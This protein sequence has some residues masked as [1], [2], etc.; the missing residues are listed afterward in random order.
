MRRTTTACALPLLAGLVTGCAEPTADDSA[1]AAA[2]EL[3]REV[4]RMIERDLALRDIA[5]ERVLA[6]MAAVPRERF[7][8]PELRGR[9]YDDGPLPIGHGQ[10][11]SQPYVVAFMTQAL[12]LDGSERVLE[13]GTGSGYQAAVLGECAAE[14][15]TIEIVEPLAD[16][17]R[18]LLAELGYDNVHVRTGDGYRGWPE[19]APFDAI[20]VTAAPDHV[21]EPLV[22]QLAEGGRMI[23]PVGDYE[24]DL[25]L[26]VKQDGQLS[27]RSVLPVRFVPMTGEARDR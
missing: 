5:D 18:A 9:A 19:E 12:E 25:V 10:T 21:P 11:I 27:R 26:L 3:P 15:Y 2:G 16:T 7:V 14:V 13:V 20:L 1:T 4:R 22:Q 24:Q 23:L 6:A 8:P 17:A